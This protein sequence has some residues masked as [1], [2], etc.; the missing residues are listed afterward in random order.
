[1]EQT[2]H[3]P[4]TVVA[5]S[6]P[7]LLDRDWLLHVTLDWKALYNVEMSPTLTDLLDCHKALF[8]DEL[9]TLKSTSA[10][11]HVDP[12][13]HPRFCKPHPVPYAMRD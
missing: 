13:S 9:G 8:C 4:L 3:L 6:G 1:M 10:K 2:A 5:G 11:L 7:S 12:Q